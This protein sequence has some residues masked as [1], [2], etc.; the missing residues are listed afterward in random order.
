M[1]SRRPRSDVPGL[2]RWEAGLVLALVAVALG[3][4]VAATL[5]RASFLFDDAGHNLLIAQTLLGGGTLYRDIF[6]QYG[7]IPAYVHAAVAAL[8]GN[9][10][11]VS[12]HLVALASS[13]NVGLAYLLVRRAAGVHVALFVSA[14][15]LLPLGLIPG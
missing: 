13:V 15:G 7:P 14:A 3:L 1:P 9:T 11:R 4:A 8:F 10:P 12:V 2:A 5:I 6:S